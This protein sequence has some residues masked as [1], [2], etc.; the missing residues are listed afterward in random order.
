MLIFQN[1]TKNYATLAF[2]SFTEKIKRDTPPT[3]SSS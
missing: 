2:A 1:L 3:K